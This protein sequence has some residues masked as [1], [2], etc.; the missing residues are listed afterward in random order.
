MR[1]LNII[2]T[3]T[4]LLPFLICNRNLIVELAICSQVE[5]QEIRFLIPDGNEFAI[6][7]SGWNTGDKCVLV[8]DDKGTNEKIDDEIVAI[9]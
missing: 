9:F 5:G 4:F 8:F 2:L 3:A 1:I 6:T 7:G